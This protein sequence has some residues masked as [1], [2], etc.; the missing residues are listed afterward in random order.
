MMGH[1][2]SK[3]ASTTAAE[4]NMINVLRRYVN[5]C[6]YVVAK[7][8]FQVFCRPNIICGEKLSLCVLP[9]H[10]QMSPFY[11]RKHVLRFSPPGSLRRRKTYFSVFCPAAENTILY[12]LIFPPHFAR[13]TD[14][15]GG[16]AVT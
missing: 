12:I 5:K 4:K 6:L 1:M 9:P 11:G 13:V 15:V 7:N 2:L 10:K 3:G 8:I 14:G 16:S